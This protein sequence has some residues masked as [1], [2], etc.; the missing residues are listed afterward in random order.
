M[1]SWGIF[2]YSVLDIILFTS[3]F[4]LDCFNIIQHFTFCVIRFSHL[5]SNPC[6][7]SYKMMLLSHPSQV[8]LKVKSGQV[9]WCS[10][11]CTVPSDAVISMHL[12]A[13]CYL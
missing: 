2:I 12:L 3:H 10:V 11:N 8:A 13:P 6:F 9:G 7:H 1:L 5:L 4:I